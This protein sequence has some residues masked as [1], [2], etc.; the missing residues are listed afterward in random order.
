MNAM[1]QDITYAIRMLRKNP[2]FTFAITLTLILGIGA[3]TAIFSVV[4]AILLRPLPFKYPDRLVRIWGNNVEKGR[5]QAP[6]SP[7]DFADWRAQNQVFEDIAAYSN[8]NPNRADGETERMAGLRIS[9][10]LFSVLGVEPALGRTFLAEEDQPKRN[11]VVMISH[12]FWQRAFGSDPSVL[13]KTLTLDGLPHTIVGVMPSDFQFPPGVEKKDLWSPIAF[14][15]NDL[16][17]RGT[18]YLQ[19]VGRLRQGLT[20]AQA[21]SDMENIAR[22]TE[23][24][25]PQTNSGWGVAVAN[26]HEELVGDIRSALLIMLGAVGFVLLTACANVTSLLLAK[27]SIRQREM[28][29]RASLGASRARLIRQMLIESVLLSLAGGALG[30][31]LALGGVKLIV[32]AAP[33]KLLRVRDVSIDGWVL[34]FTLVI[35]LLSGMAFGLLPALQASK[36][37]LNES[38]KEGSQS[39]AG[40]RGRLR[41]RNGLVVCEIA[42]ALV[43][44]VG[45]GLMIKSFARLM[46]V[47]S[48]LNPTG[49]LTAQI[50]LPSA[51]YSTPEQERAFFRQ[52]LERI[53]ALPGVQHA[54]ITSF[55]PLGGT[56]MDWLFAIEGRPVSD[57]SEILYAEY[58]Q[59]S[60]GYFQ[61]M[62]TPIIRGRDFSD[63]DTENTP[64]V[65]IINQ[66]FGRRFFAN[67]EPLGKRIG[68]GKKPV[69]RE[70]IGVV[71]DVRH[72][73]LDAEPKAEA[74]VTHLQDPWPSMAVVVRST[75][76]INNL[77]AIIR[78]EVRVIDKNQP[79]YNVRSMQEL[80]S[81]SVAPRRLSMLLLSI[82]SAVALVLA[83]VGVY[84]VVAYSVVQRTHEIGVRMALGAQQNDVLKLLVGQGIRLGSAG[85]ILGSLAAFAIT[86]VLSSLLYQVSSTDLTIFI[87]LSLALA[88]IVVL[89]SY[90]PARRAT[91]IDPAVALRCG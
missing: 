80:I 43:L 41:I 60:D 91:K 29:I 19:V 10:S 11:Q 46:S 59:V 47:D 23:Q 71:A 26:L 87:S 3:N 79:V 14:S 85:V 2:G 69:W 1:L 57:P 45:A 4:N 48:G 74:Y 86:R 68:F 17:L 5:N 82:F 56:N 73:G 32:A 51:R 62:G 76:E 84:S 31:F 35:S 40:S 53:E 90:L 24:Q 61:A 33:V 39:L 72:F 12:G 36:I 44:L 58:R 81:S 64:G 78:G 37:N 20:L 13:G 15:P 50:S 34:I 66:A 7:A 38:L 65:I 55:L 9:A 28:A 70:I 89:A 42:L 8:W 22:Q 30:T 54:G 49:V 63:R 21:K 6:I 75:S 16:S 18:R 25:Y 88:C 52:L 67:E 27:A 77:A 83:A